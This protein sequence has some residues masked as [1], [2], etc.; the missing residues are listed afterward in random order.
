[1]LKFQCISVSIGIP[2]IIFQL[3]HANSEVKRQQIIE[4]VTFIEERLSELDEE[5]EELRKYQELDK[6]HRSLEY[7]IFDKE[8]AETKTKLDKV[9]HRE[10]HVRFVIFSLDWNVSYLFSLG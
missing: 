6:Q 10:N 2:S 4:V 8:L 9:N 1:M 7:T 5:K 3:M